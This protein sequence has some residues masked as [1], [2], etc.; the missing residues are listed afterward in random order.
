MF[1]LAV[2]PDKYI[3]AIGE[4]IIKKLEERPISGNSL[5]MKDFENQI[6]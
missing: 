3:Q 6:K 5:P 2:N 1:V 4:K